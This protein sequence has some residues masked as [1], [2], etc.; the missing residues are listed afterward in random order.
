MSNLKENHFGY[1]E[2]FSDQCSLSY[3]II[4]KIENQNYR[5]WF[6]TMRWLK[7]QIVI[8]FDNQ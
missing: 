5:F 1:L 7:K 2:F 6:H 8:A 4:K 3:L